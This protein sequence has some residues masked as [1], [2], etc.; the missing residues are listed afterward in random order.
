MLLTLLN[1]HP[2]TSALTAIYNS[3]TDYSNYEDLTTDVVFDLSYVYSAYTGTTVIPMS[4]KDISGTMLQGTTNNTIGPAV[5]PEI[6]STNGGP[7]VV[8]SASTDYMYYKVKKSGS[9]RFQYKGKEKGTLYVT[10]SYTGK[11]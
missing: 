11:S 2:S 8:T 3:Y 7:L 10:T 9:Y 4:G 6:L 5:K 1:T